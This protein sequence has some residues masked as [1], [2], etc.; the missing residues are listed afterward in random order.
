MNHISSL[1]SSIDIE[2][3]TV[4]IMCLYLLY[5]KL[6]SLLKYSNFLEFQKNNNKNIY[7]YLQARP[8]ETAKTA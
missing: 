2:V 6:F 3:D 4:L 1:I 7:F 8:L 5:L